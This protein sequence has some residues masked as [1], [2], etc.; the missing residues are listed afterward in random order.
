[1]TWFDALHGNATT[2]REVLATASAS[3]SV[4]E[5]IVQSASEAL[6]SQVALLVNVLDPE[7]VVI[8]GGLGMINGPYWVHFIAFT[9]RHIWFELHR[10]LPILR[11]ATGVD[12]GWIGVAAKAWRE[13]PNGLNQ[14]QALKSKT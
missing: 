14:S 4:A 3:N 11:A 10:D 8:A 6:E 13:F 12:T 1:M 5:K 2:S 7:A 9:R